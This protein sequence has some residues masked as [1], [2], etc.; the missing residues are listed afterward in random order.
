M[1]AKKAPFKVWAGT[2]AKA[3]PRKMTYQNVY[4]RHINA[5]DTELQDSVSF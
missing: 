5:V 1:E 3:M 4:C 2:E